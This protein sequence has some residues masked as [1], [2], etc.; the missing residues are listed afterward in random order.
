MSKIIAD[1]LRTYDLKGKGVNA[2]NLQPSDLLNEMLIDI[3][4]IDISSFLNNQFI[5]FIMLIGF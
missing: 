4:N 3:L 2:Q 5:E 1:T